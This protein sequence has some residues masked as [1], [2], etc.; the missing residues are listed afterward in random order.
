[1]A[2]YD[3]EELDFLSRQAVEAA[4]ER[5]LHQ[6]PFHKTILLPD[7]HGRRT[8]IE[9]VETKEAQYHHQALSVAS[10]VEAI[11]DDSFGGDGSIGVVM[12]G[13]GRVYA[14]LGLQDDLLERAW[15]VD[16]APSVERGA[17]ESLN[18]PVDQET[19]WE[20]LVGPLHTCAPP[21][22]LLVISNLSFST[23]KGG[24]LEIGPMGQGRKAEAGFTITHRPAGSDQPQTDQL[25][26]EWTFQAPYFE[27]FREATYEFDGF[28]SA[29][30]VEDKL[31]LRLRLRNREEVERR[32]RADLVKH[33]REQLA[34]TAW[35][36]YEAEWQSL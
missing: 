25:R 31:R 33:L 34:G 36:V 7:E 6:G 23:R 19:F 28:L 2:D 10:L 9:R 20:A 24:A 11:K 21:E 5:V 13:A 1:M 30:I 16:L 12:V 18:T 17:L 14:R 15:C 8:R 26:A 22:L 29:R 27:V 35:P 3:A 4:Q 32:A